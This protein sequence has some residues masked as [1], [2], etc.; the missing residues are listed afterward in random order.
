MHELE[1][2][3]TATI[4]T[5]PRHSDL[6]PG[7]QGQHTTLV[8]TI[9]TELA[10]IPSPAPVAAS[11]DYRRIAKVSPLARS[12]TQE[13]RD[14]VSQGLLV[15][16][17]NDLP[18]GHVDFLLQPTLLLLTL[19]ALDIPSLAGLLATGYPLA[20]ASHLSCSLVY[21]ANDNKVA[22]LFQQSVALLLT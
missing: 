9:P 21:Q 20:Q 10:A 18:N 15:R 19:G 5:Q 17:L 6:G 1:V 16:L 2:D 8:G 14:L 4:A 22:G 11:L 7:V 3:D 12:S 13:R